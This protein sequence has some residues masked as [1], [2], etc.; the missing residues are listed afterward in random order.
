MK[1]IA[2]YISTLVVGLNFGLAACSPDEVSHP[3]EAGKPTLADYADRISITVD[4]STN[5]VTFALAPGTTGVMPV[6]LFDGKTYSTVNGLQK[7]YTKAGEYA[8]DVQLLNA[9][10]VSDGTIR[11]TFKLDN[12]IFDFSKYQT[13]LTGG[14]GKTKTWRVAAELDKH[15]GCGPSGTTGTEWYAAK[16]GEKAGTGLYDLRLDFAW[17]GSYTFD[18]RS[19]G[20][21][22]VN[23]GSSEV[24]PEYNTAG[25][26]YSVPM[27]KSSSTYSFDVVGE[28]L[29]LVL[30]PKTPMPYVP[31]NAL[32]NAPRW[33]VESMSAS[34]MELI[35]DE[36]T[37]AWHLTLV[38]GE[39]SDVQ[40]APTDPTIFDPAWSGNLWRKAKVRE[41]FVFYAPGWQ[42]IAN[43]EVTTSGF[44]HTVKLPEATGERW[45]AQMAFKT[46]L[47]MQAGK[48]YDFYVVLQ[49]SQD[50][51]GVTIKLVQDGDDNNFYF[52]DRHAL[53]A[54]EDFVYKVSN[55]EGKDMPA[56]N[57]FFDFGGNVA[58]TDI[59]IKDIIVQEH[60]E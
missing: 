50:H 29:Y 7:L 14:E 56:T 58:N 24:Y 45:Q 13:M 39:P 17:D 48:K 42:Q 34:K 5:Q 6:W 40:P 37:I 44:A 10:G 22:Y 53:K 43:P 35:M 30:P 46:D 52:D 25:A 57:L 33:R 2:L 26:D 19:A 31:N 18:P 21:M 38:T 41:M 23:T 15:L 27:P 8:V 60:R 59:V 12:T 1:R 32:W 28:N 36:G 54:Y 20:M 3:S 51:P 11:R 4:Q 16:A 9:N 47:A 55:F 49:S